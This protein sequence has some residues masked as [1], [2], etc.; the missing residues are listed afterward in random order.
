MPVPITQGKDFNFFQTLAVTDGYFNHNPLNDADVF[1]N[2][3]GQVSFSLVNEG[4]GIIQYSFN[5]QTLHG[6]MTPGTPTQ[7]IFFD[8]RRVS[9][10]WF[11]LR[12]GQPDSTVR[13]E[14]WGAM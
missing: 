4:A 10:I 2:F 12:G 6:D 14:A 11:R 13:V 1:F 5:G 9:K 3:R 7:A 8:N